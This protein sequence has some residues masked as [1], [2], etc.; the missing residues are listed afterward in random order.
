MKIFLVLLSACLAMN[1]SAQTLKDALY[2]GKL[3]T[4]SG[5][6]LRKGEDLTGKIDTA[7]KK[8]PVPEKA[9]PL[10]VSKDT[11]V[12]SADGLTTMEPAPA[13]PV[14]EAKD[15]NKTWKAYADEVVKTM[16]QE[17]MTSKKVKKGEYAVVLD[18]EI[19]LEGQVTITNVFVTPDNKFITEQIRERFSIDTPK[20]NPVLNSS[21]KPRK[22]VKRTNFTL[23]SQ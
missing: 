3:K 20:L 12:K 10:S 21:G 11:A 13:N 8:D 22:T 17:V 9:K 19:G 14:A 23:I 18:Y 2:S 16:N 15:N 4:D 7:R 1:V 5:T 6:V